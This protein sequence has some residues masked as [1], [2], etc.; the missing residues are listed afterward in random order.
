MDSVAL[1]NLYV[2]PKR[3]ECEVIRVART[4]MFDKQLFQKL[5]KDHMIN[6]ITGEV[7]EI[8]RTKDIAKKVRKKMNDIRR[9]AHNNFFNAP[10]EVFVTL[11]YSE[12]KTS[13][14][15]VLKDMKK[16]INRVKYHCKGDELKYIGIIEPHENGNLHCHFLIKNMSKEVFTIK[17]E[18]LQKLWKHGIVSITRIYNAAG[19]ALYLTACKKKIPNLKYYTTTKF[20]ILSRN[21][22]KPKKVSIH[23]YGQKINSCIVPS[24]GRNL[25]YFKRIDIIKEVPDDIAREYGVKKQ[26]INS[27]QREHYKFSS[28]KD[29]INYIKSLPQKYADE[30]LPS[31]PLLGFG[32]LK[33]GDCYYLQYKTI[34]VKKSFIYKV[35]RKKFNIN[36]NRPIK[37]S[38][39]SALL[40]V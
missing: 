38:V 25:V 3:K 19:I 31:N 7:I 29:F 8:D 33:I 13:F 4:N 22:K 6:I 2:Y 10:N 15:E 24:D 30:I 1:I 34:K 26:V 20:F 16:F 11:E 32:T 28:T 14:G 35:L 23:R 39:I 18:K 21:L 9:L 17:H 27:I 12:P 5:D 40:T 37:Q 36:F